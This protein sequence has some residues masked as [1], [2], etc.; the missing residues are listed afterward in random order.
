MVLDPVEANKFFCCSRYCGKKCDLF[1]IPAFEN[2][3]VTL[4]DDRATHRFRLFPGV[5]D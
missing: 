4:P 1:Q 2:H 3:D 5:V